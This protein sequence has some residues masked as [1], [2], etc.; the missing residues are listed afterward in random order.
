MGGLKPSVIYTPDPV[1]PQLVDTGTRRNIRLTAS[2]AKV[3]VKFDG[4]Q[5]AKELALWAANE[6]L[7]I[8]P[9][10]VQVVLERLEHAGFLL[11]A[12]HVPPQDLRDVAFGPTDDPL[13]PE[14]IVPSMR[15]D[16]KIVA[17]AGARSTYQVSDPGAHRA[18]T[19][20]DFEVSIARMLDG[21]RTAAQ[22]VE[23]AATIGI[24]LTVDSLRRF[25][26]QLKAFKF[27]SAEPANIKRGA[28][29]TWPMRAEWTEDLRQLFQNA[30]RLLRTAKLKESR[31]YLMAMLEIDPMNKEAQEFKARVDELMREPIVE[32]TFGDLHR[33]PASSTG[34]LLDSNLRVAVALSPE[35][36]GP[37]V[38]LAPVSVSAPSLLPVGSRP[39]APE[40]PV[41]QPAPVAIDLL[42]EIAD[43]TPMEPEPVPPEPLTM[44][45]VYEEP[46]VGTPVPPVLTPVER[47]EPPPVLPEPLPQPSA[48]AVTES[49]I[50][51]TVFAPPPS[52][53]KP[54]SAISADELGAALPKMPSMPSIVVDG[55]EP[56]VIPQAAMAAPVV[57]SPPPP[58][59]EPE[60]VPPPRKKG[61]ARRVVIALLLIGIAVLLAIPTPR[62]TSV[63]CELSQLELATVTSPRPGV[64]DQLPVTEGQ[65]VEKGQLLATLAAKETET[66]LERAKARAASMEQQ[67]E[68]LAKSVKPAEVEKARAALAEKTKELTQATEHKR[69]VEAKHSPASAVAKAEKDVKAKQTAVDKATAEVDK[70]SHESKLA[71]NR[72]V[73]EGL[74]KQSAQLEAE[75]EAAKIVA[76]EAGKLEGLVAAGSTLADH[77]VVARIVAPGKLGVSAKA[78]DVA[79]DPKSGTVT[80]GN[81]SW[82]ISDLGRANDALKGT[83]EAKDAKPGPATL[84][85]SLGKRSW[86]FDLIKLAKQRMH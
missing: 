73:L 17:T 67:L 25:L 52:V 14:H 15:N 56:E 3:L 45:P 74:K 2:E 80:A 29:S 40:M 54:I 26:L 63:P 57:E 21:R 49:I 66:Q 38:P 71:S 47:V 41:V 19:L 42:P 83:L 33:E 44:E 86:A 32:L 81:A 82:P 59:P 6:G 31:E 48:P 34:A 58:E 8:G 5:T 72:L 27:L 70:L 12:P 51:D 55:I 10:Q 79:G 36:L 1:A 20:F 75:L 78:G 62:S 11:T 61:G 22:V 85:V 18:F 28:Q 53:P 9:L 50:S 60:P 23:A 68:A 84:T 30:L 24:T 13:K 77:A 16:L 43:A 7:A 37:I 76:P 39:T 35:E 69:K 4:S 65:V 46:I 64:I